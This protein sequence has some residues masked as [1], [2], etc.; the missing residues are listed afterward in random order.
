MT[1]V[2]HSIFIDRP[3]A[4]VFAFV[5]DFR[6]DNLW[7]KS[8][9]HTEK[10]TPGDIAVGTQFIQDS[11]VLFVVIKG[12]L[13]VLEWNPPRLVRYRNESS[14]LLYDLLY[15]FDAEGSGT[16]FT[17]EASLE[18]KGALRLLK[19]ITMQTLHGKLRTYFG[20]LKDVLENSPITQLAG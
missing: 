5:T 14:N 17:L 6:N 20:L 11:K 18:M 16:R 3:P 19:P 15:Q 7:W 12:H 4:E 10:V 13:E 1:L 2:T 8:V 9:I